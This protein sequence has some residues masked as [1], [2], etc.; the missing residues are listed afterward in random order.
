LW[1]YPGT[2]LTVDLDGTTLSL[3][4]VGGLKALQSSFKQI[5]KK[6]IQ[7]IGHPDDLP[8]MFDASLQSFEI[9]NQIR[10]LFIRISIDQAFHHKRTTTQNSFTSNFF[11][12]H[13]YT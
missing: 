1:P 7:Q 4:I 13:K 11:N 9:G 2:E 5:L 10:H 8:R 12:G 3:P 6:I